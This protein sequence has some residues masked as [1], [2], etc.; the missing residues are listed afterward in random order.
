MKENYQKHF[1][2]LMLLFCIL[3]SQYSSGSMVKSTDNSILVKDIA[4]MSYETT[5]CAGTSAVADQGSFSTGYSYSFHTT[6]NDVTVTFELLDTDKVGVVAYLWQQ[7]PFSETPMDNVS[8][9]RFSKTITGQTAG[10]TVNY[11]VKF[12]YAGGLS[13]T[14]YI[15]YVV[16]ENCDGGGNEDTQV[17][18]GFTATAGTITA[19]SAELLL[20]ATDDSGSVIYTVTYG[21]TTTSVT[22][23]SGVQ[24]VFVINGLTPETAYSFS[25]T[26]SDAAGNTALNNPVVVTA[27]TLEDANTPCAGTSAT[28]QDGTFSTGYSYSFHTTGNDVTVTFE[29][30][31][32]DKVGVV[33]YLWQQA[34]FSETPMDN[35][36][37]LRFSKNITG[38]TTGAT[39]NYAVKFAYAGGL[40]VTQYISYVVGENCDGGGNE[41]TQAPTGFTATAGTITATSAELLLNGTDDSGTVIYTVTYGTTTT[42]VTGSSGVQQ[43]FVINGLTPETAYSFSVTASDA[44]GNTALNNP[45]IVTA[46]TLEDTNTPCAGTSATAQDGTFTTGYSYNFHTTGNDV[47]VTFELLDTDKVGVV[48]YL[49]QQAPFSETPMDNVSGLRFSKTIMGQTAGATVNYAVKFAY[50]GGL[51]VT[52]YISYVVGENC[53]GGGNEDT[54]APTGFTATAGTITATSAELLLNGTDDS[55]SV[56]YTVTYGTTTTS[57]TGTS[58]VQQAFVING[59]T[60]ETAYSFSV[61]AS[62]TAGNTALNNPVVVTATT[63]EDT[64]TPCAGTSATAQDGTFTTGY[65]YNFHTTGNDVTITF[66]LLDT[67]KVGVVAYLWQQAPFSETPMDN[68]SG[69]RFSK[70]ITGQTAGTT[71]NYAVKF[72]YA[73]GLSVTKYFSYMVG[74]NCTLEIVDRQFDNDVKLY[75]NPTDTGVVHVVSEFLRVSKVEVYSVLGNKLF[76][77]TERTISVNNLQVGIYLFRIY[78]DD[79]FVTKK[80]IIK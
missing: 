47:T 45:V 34:P 13:V 31:D 59:L 75:P 65:S 2:F 8:G 43:A 23:T 1:S 52:Q 71:I 39:I 61:T 3:A 78:A 11:A 36:S 80:L 21:T 29:L 79:K 44:A 56:I 49:W 67:D 28:A 37:G 68:V 55:G 10:T 57:V 46:T 48:A 32:T 30:L 77:T 38:Q 42:S 14:Q 76:E 18:T 16:G 24:K 60:P 62:D 4:G 20:N 7:A 35:V 73:G 27:T 66:E 9:L 54:Q 69:L 12:A 17:P 6:G 51:S 53:D 25:V 41:D 63:L 33:A 15:S 19:T 58:G 70:T 22:G 64:N 50:A 5:P 26:A 74:D 40:S 72:A